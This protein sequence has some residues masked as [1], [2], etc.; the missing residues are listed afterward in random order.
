MLYR[1]IIIALLLLPLAGTPAGAQQ[2]MTQGTPN[3][4]QVVDIARQ[5]S[6]TEQEAIAFR[7]LQSEL[8]VAAL[9]CRDARHRAHYNIFITR[10]RSMLGHNARLLKTY[11][12]RLHGPMAS[13]KLDT[14]ITRLANEASL[15]S[16]SDADFCLNALARFEV[17]N[18]TDRNQTAGMIVEEADLV[19][20]Q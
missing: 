18:H 16:M 17:V 6:F 7:R 2:S 10:F 1:G 19:L 14:F 3:R 15:A 13:R 8:M 11:F 12:R 20:D 5:P 4:A 9:A